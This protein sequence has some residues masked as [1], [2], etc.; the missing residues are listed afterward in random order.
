MTTNTHESDVNT[1]RLAHPDASHV[2]RC[3]IDDVHIETTADARLIDVADA[4][5]IPLPRFCYHK[6]L[7]VAANCRMC[8][9]EVAGAAKPVPACTATVTDGMK[10][11]TQSAMA[12]NAQKSVMEFLL[13]NH[14]LDCP[15]CD[16]GG[17]CEL[18]DVAVVV[19]A[20][21]VEEYVLTVRLVQ[22]G[23]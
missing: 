13:I 6:E 22:I 9:V 15:I 12:V 14:P 11:L 8:L 20:P 19:R 2:I 10:V 1:L 17:E 4:A 21:G 7:T 3:Q 18:Q 5:G 16:Q 23:D